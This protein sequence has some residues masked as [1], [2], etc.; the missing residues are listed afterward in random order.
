M[1]NRDLPTE[2]RAAPKLRRDESHNHLAMSATKAVLWV[3]DFAIHDPMQLVKVKGI[4]KIYFFK[5]SYMYVKIGYNI[6]P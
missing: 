1:I 6:F 2:S 5:K 3:P 4:A